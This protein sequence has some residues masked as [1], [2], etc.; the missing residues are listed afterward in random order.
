MILSPEY[1]A[2]ACLQFTLGEIVTKLS[3][4][5]IH[6]SGNTFSSECRLNAEIKCFQMVV[7]LLKIHPTDLATFG[8]FNHYAEFIRTMIWFC[9][10]SYIPS[11]GYKNELPI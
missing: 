10:I 3:G 9:T 2:H 6:F 1:L 4:K 8:S 7:M 11:C 5:F